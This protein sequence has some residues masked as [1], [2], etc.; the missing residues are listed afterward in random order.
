MFLLDSGAQF[1]KRQLKSTLMSVAVLLWLD[2]FVLLAK[3]GVSGLKAQLYCQTY[4]TLWT[5]NR[6]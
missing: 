3:I 4:F 6:C 5:E 2:L 1:V